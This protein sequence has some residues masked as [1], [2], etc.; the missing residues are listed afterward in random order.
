MHP[1]NGPVFSLP[2]PFSSGRLTTREPWLNKT[3]AFRDVAKSSPGEGEEGLEKGARPD[4]TSNG[5]KGY[6]SSLLTVTRAKSISRMA[7]FLRCRNLP[8]Q[9][10]YVSLEL[11][12]FPPPSRSFRAG[13][14]GHTDLR[15][16]ENELNWEGRGDATIFFNPPCLRRMICQEMGKY[17]LREVYAF[18]LKLR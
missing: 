17:E 18:V 6:L 11:G 14:L 7:G 8:E 3:F 10:L 2:L 13:T 4:S 15:G 16:K 1:H 9:T 12:I 5:R